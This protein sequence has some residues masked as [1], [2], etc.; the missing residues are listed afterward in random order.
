MTMNIREQVRSLIS[1]GRTLEQVMAAQPT[2]AYD[3][4]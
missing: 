2:A 3:A 4:Q 1:E